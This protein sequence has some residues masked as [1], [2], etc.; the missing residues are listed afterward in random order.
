MPAKLSRTTRMPYGMTNAAYR[1]TMGNSGVPDPTWARTIALEYINN[2][3]L[4]A[5]TANGSAAMAT[6]AGVG[7]SATLTTGAS[8]NTL[9]AFA[10]AQAVFQVPTVANNLGR[11]F[12]KWQ[13]SI[14]SLL[15]TLQVGFVASAASSPQGVYIQSTG[16]LSLIV[17]NGS[18]TTTVPF[19]SALTLVA[20][21]SVELGIE[22]DTLG[23]VFGY[24]NPTTGAEPITGTVPSTPIGTVSNGP[25]VA[26]YN[27]LNGSLQGLF[28]PTAAL[29]ASQGAIP[30]TAVA[31]VLTVNFFVGIQEVTPN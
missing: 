10:T 19:P 30:T 1:Q 24:Y 28:L 8:A 14:D 20:G 17:K 26:A 27:Q 18:G 15:G 11:M 22:I 6:T 9:G 21:T 3:D 25:V 23:N 5:L 7:G 16:A 4:T 31:R 12:F 29:Y 2:G 13:G